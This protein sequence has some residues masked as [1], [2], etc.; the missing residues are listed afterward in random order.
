LQRLCRQHDALPVR[1]RRRKQSLDKRPAAFSPQE[2]CFCGV[3]INVIGVSRAGSVQ[4]RKYTSLIS[5]NLLLLQFFTTAAP[6]KSYRR[7]VACYVFIRGRVQ[8]EDRTTG[9]TAQQAKQF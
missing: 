6:Q 5:L 2:L 8:A 9:F 7:D 3:L 4:A 1:A